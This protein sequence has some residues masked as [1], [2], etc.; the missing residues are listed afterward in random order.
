M[1]MKLGYKSH[2]YSIFIFLFI[3]LLSVCYVLPSGSIAGFINIKIIALFLSFI[4]LVFF[5]PKP[6]ILAASIF[7]I[8]LSPWLVLGVINGYGYLSFSQFKD[9]YVTFFIVFMTLL[10]IYNMQGDCKKLLSVFFVCAVSLAILKLIIYFFSIVTGNPVSFYINLI[11]AFFGVKL[12]TLDVSNGGFGRINF[13]SDY[14]IPYLIFY[15]LQYG[16]SYTRSVAVRYFIVLFL[17]ISSF[18]SFSRFIWGMTILSILGAVFLSN[19]KQRLLIIVLI[20]LCSSFFMIS[21]VSDALALR[22]STQQVS[23][24]DGIRDIQYKFLME[25]F[26]SSPIIGNGLGSYVKEYI[27]SADAMY[28][29]ELQVNA[30]LMQVGVIGVMILFFL[31][32]CLYM[33]P[34]MKIKFIT[35]RFIF[36]L[37]F[38]SWLGSGFFNPV[39]FSSMGGV[40]F[41]FFLLYPSTIFYKDNLR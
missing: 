35:D 21:D 34:F 19:L 25:E 30:L 14:L 11:S 16:Q 15:L 31:I 29:Y 33:K 9:I 41:S 7:F 22:F 6:T 2:R 3:V 27:R 10:Y 36:S 5:K 1:D 40:I 23:S 13:I 20:L 39:L 12:M 4:W 28:S 32:V 17:I 38:L 26:D 18:A 37:L 8:V 24:S